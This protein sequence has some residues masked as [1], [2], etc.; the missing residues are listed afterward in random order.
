MKILTPAAV[1]AHGHVMR[2]RANWAETPKARIESRQVRR[3]KQR[4]MAWDSVAPAPSKSRS[5]RRHEAREI[6]A[7]ARSRHS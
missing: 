2:R 5:E 3:A 4:R 6:V 1:R 7:Q